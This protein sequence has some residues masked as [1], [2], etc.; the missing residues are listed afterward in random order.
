ME[1][2]LMSP[3]KIGL[4]PMRLSKPRT[5]WMVGNFYYHVT[6][7]SLPPNYSPD[8]NSFDNCMWSE[9]RLGGAERGG[10]VRGVVEKKVN[11]NPHNTKS[12]LMGAMTRAMEDMNK[13]PLIRA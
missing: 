11:K 12:S 6:P 10:R 4:H 13:D 2:D 9:V 7:N 3:N 5:G 1:E 8:L